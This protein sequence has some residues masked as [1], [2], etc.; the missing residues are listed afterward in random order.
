MTSKTIGILGLGIF[1]STIAKTLSTYDCDVIAIDKAEENVNRLEAYITKGIVGD[2]TDDELLT[3]CGIGD[4]DVVIVASGSS[5]ESSIL[6][7]MHCKNLGVPEIICKAKSRISTE[8]L[9]QM[10]AHKVISPEKDTAVRVARNILHRRISDIIQLD[11]NISLIEFYPPKSWIGKS[12][13]ELNLRKKY[14]LNLIGYRNGPN[15]KL[16]IQF[17]ADYRLKESE[18]IV[19]IT[20]SNSFEQSDYFDDFTN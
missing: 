6:A 9:S 17:T 16:N 4:C 1:G 15:E 7:V 20:E 2:I 19:A 12:L 8:I 14:D 13:Q 5:L 11:N 3:A 18:L 10:G